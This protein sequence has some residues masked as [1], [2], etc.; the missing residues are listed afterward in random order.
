MKRNDSTASKQP[1]FLLL[2]LGTMLVILLLVFA[3][4]FYLDRSAAEEQLQETIDYVKSQTL[5]RSRYTSATEVKSL[6]RCAENVRQVARDLTYLTDE[7]VDEALLE[8]LAQEQHLTGILLL[9]PTGEVVCQ[10]TSD[11]DADAALADYWKRQAVLGTADSTVKT[12]AHRIDL[13]DNSY[14][15]LAAC[16]RLDASGVVVAYRHLSATIAQNYDIT[17]QELLSG[18][19]SQGHEVIAITSGSRIVAS[20]DTSLIGT[21]VDNHTVL[22]TLRQVADSNTRRIHAL[23]GGRYFGGMERG[24]DYYLYVYMPAADVFEFTP[25][26]LLLTM[27]LYTL[28]MVLLQLYLRRSTRIYEEEKL[29]QDQEYQ[30]M[31]LDSVHRAEAANTAKTTFLQRMSHDI[32]TPINVILGMLDMSEHSQGDPEK[33]ADCHRK[34]RDA[35]E[36]LLE[37]VSDVLDMGK[38]ESGEIVLESRPFD[39]RQLL[40]ELVSILSQQVQARNITLA[41]GDTQVQHWN[42]IGSPIHLKRLLMNILTNAVKYNKDGGSITFSCLEHPGDEPG[43]VRMEFICAD[44]GIG[45]SPDYQPYVFDAFTQE[46]N[47]ARTSYSGTG[48]GMSIVKSLTEQMGGTIRFE[49]TQGVGTTFF[50]S[51]PFQI[52]QQAAAEAKE[53]SSGGITGMRILLVEDNQLNMEIAQFILENAGAIVTQAVNGRI[54]LETFQASQPGA[55]DAILMDIMMPEMDGL[56]ATRAIR[57]LD[58][59][60]AKTIPIIAM[61]ANAFAEDRQRAFEAGMTDHL[62]KPLNADTL[63]NTIAKYK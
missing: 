24:R 42:L 50:I 9:S 14:T 20:N 62:A 30:E 25:K 51:I 8:R 34:I 31:L 38:L 63:V 53:P 55:F 21:S 37:L 18:Y 1:A 56:E 60:D 40:N 17:L 15:N 39:L 27:A 5:L 16:G 12:Y 33:Q 35:S 26:N 6:I 48:L 28:L 57:A 58:R 41:Q 59:P 61:T 43:T 7:T 2:T 49:S 44:T 19:V 10:Y 46:A 13:P 32:R 11:P 36:L 54:A 45:M 47:S 22:E 4:S 29:R 23:N 3:L 52:D